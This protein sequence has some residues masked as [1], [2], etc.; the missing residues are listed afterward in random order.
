M[1]IF[2]EQYD[3]AIS[4]LLL[5]NRDRYISLEEEPQEDTYDRIVGRERPDSSL[6]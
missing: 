4:L 1:T 2:S 5:E 3:F 6:A